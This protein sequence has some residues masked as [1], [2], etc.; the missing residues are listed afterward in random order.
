MQLPDSQGFSLLGLQEGTGFLLDRFLDGRFLPRGEVG[1]T[2]RISRR[3]GTRPMGACFGADVGHQDLPRT[4]RTRLR[5]V[6]ILHGLLADPLDGLLVTALLRGALTAIAL[7]R[8]P[9][10]RPPQ[11]AQTSPD[12]VP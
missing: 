4:P 9:P 12:A 7:K 1:R 6:P 5:P 3:L 11:T 8:D 10:N 2:T